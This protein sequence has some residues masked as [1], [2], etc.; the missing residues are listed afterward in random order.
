[1]R[2]DPPPEPGFARREARYDK[3]VEAETAVAGSLG[4][5]TKPPLARRGLAGEP[6]VSLR[7]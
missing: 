2:I 4:V 7:Y 6:G 1:M 3:N 5:V